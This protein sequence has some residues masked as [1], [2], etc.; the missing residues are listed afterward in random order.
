MRPLGAVLALALLAGRAQAEE[1]AT[2]PVPPAAMELRMVRPDQQLARLLALFEGSR[3]PHPAAALARWRQATGR[4]DVLS[5]PWQA[6]IAALNPLMVEE[7]RL[8]DAARLAVGLD[9]DGRWRWHLIVP[10]DDGTLDALASALAL[11]DGGAEAPL[12]G[13]AVDRLGRGDAV[14]LARRGESVVLAGSR[15]DLARGLAALRGPDALNPADLVSGWLLHVDPAGLAAATGPPLSTAGAVLRAL[16]R[17]PV[18]VRLG[19]DGEQLG[20]VARSATDAPFVGPPEPARAI[21]PAWL[22]AVAA[23][24]PDRVALLVLALNPGGVT[25]RRL[26]AVADALQAPGPG[27]LAPMATRARL[28]LLAALAGVRPDVDLWPRLAGI[29]IEARADRQG[30]PLG[31]RLTL[32]ATNPDAASD[33]AGR[34]VPRIARAAGLRGIEAGEAR[35]AGEPLTL[36]RRDATLILTWGPPPADPAPGPGP[37]WRQ[38]L[39][40]QAALRLVAVWPERLAVG[41]RAGEPVQDALVG[42]PPVVWIGR[43]EDDRAVDTVAWTGLRGTI[44]RVL[45]RLPQAVPPYPGPPAAAA[46]PDAESP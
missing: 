9:P 14:R 30:R 41:L 10:H 8:L 39:A 13:A 18:E 22:D 32:H 45:D 40:D 17:G 42:T 5:K 29:T 15:D 20:L 19:L 44:R 16:E 26:F 28:N 3:A 21:D 31:L 11:T 34:V 6:A 7:L 38:R 1:P 36:A 37:G 25:V 24:D 43:A 33:L 46:R 27:R 12:D 2:A 23:D 35:L 4:H